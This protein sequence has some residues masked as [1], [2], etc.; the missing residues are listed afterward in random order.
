[1]FAERRKGEGS[2]VGGDAVKAVNGVVVKRRVVL[3]L[4]WCGF[5]VSFCF[6]FDLGDI[7]EERFRFLLCWGARTRCHDGR[8]SWSLQAEALDTVLVGDARADEAAVR[9][10]RII[11]VYLLGLVVFSVRLEQVYWLV[12]LGNMDGESPGALGGGGHLSG[13]LYL[14]RLHQT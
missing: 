7:I 6:G 14:I 12:V 4:C 1:M 10:R 13:L 8:M 9:A 3:G 5:A 11:G 2:L